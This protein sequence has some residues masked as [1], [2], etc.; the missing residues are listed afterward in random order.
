MIMCSPGFAG[1]TT[2][3][4]TIVLM[5]VQ[6]HDNLV[7]FM[8]SNE[9]SSKNVS[10]RNNRLTKTMI[11]TPYYRHIRWISLVYIDTDTDTRALDPWQALLSCA[12]RCHQWMW[13]SQHQVNVIL[14]HTAQNHLQHIKHLQV[15]KAIWKTIWQAIWKAVWTLL[16]RSCTFAADPYNRCESVGQ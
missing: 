2:P 4:F 3:G 15:W 11:V 6:Q 1:C 9:C 14:S 8:V 16:T 7:E 10:F 12:V 5:H 13:V